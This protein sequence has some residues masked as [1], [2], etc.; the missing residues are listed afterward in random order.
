MHV[1][2]CLNKGNFIIL[3]IYFIINSTRQII[4]VFCACLWRE[5]LNNYVN[6]II[7]TLYKTL[8]ADKVS[9][10]ICM[11]HINF[12]TVSYLI[13]ISSVDIFSEGSFNARTILK[14]MLKNARDK[15][16]NKLS[17]MTTVLSQPKPFQSEKR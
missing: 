3:Y 16:I 4:Y 2:L 5:G 15:N 9:N 17:I 8:P 10:D 11:A 14:N 13:N 7:Y 6:Y 1:L 12:N